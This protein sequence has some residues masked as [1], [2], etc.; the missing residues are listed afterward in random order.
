MTGKQRQHDINKKGRKRKKEGNR[1]M[2]KEEGP[3]SSPQVF[4]L[5]LYEKT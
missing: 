2:G 1:G 4:S 3:P 5:S